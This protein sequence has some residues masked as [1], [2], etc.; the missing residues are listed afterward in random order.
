MI[1]NSTR[2]II[3]A[4]VRD[5]KRS[6]R[7]GTEMRIMATEDS[8]LYMKAFSRTWKTLHT[9]DLRIRKEKETGRLAGARSYRISPFLTIYV[10]GSYQLAERLYQGEIWLD[11]YAAEKF[12]AMYIQ[13][14]KE[15]DR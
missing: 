8:S 4:A 9:E 6:F 10:G 15:E 5:A 2:A 13:D 14:K 7:S 3:R 12:V 1:R 11:E